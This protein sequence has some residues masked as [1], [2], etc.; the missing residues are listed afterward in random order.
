MA[1]VASGLSKM[2]VLNISYSCGRKVLLP[3]SPSWRSEF[4]SV[5]LNTDPLICL[6][7]WLNWCSLR[8]PQYC[9]SNLFLCSCRALVMLMSSC[10]SLRSCWFSILMRCVC[11]LR[12]SDA[13]CEMD[14]VNSLQISGPLKSVFRLQVEFL[15]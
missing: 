1:G 2:Q 14:T 4:N 15:Q 6:R 9:F 3:S 10:S 13:S 8:R 5:P 12:H 11:F 7:F